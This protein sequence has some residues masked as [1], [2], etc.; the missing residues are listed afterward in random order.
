MSH[1]VSFIIQIA[2]NST[3]LPI[4]WPSRRWTRR[5][6]AT[7]VNVK[8]IFCISRRS[9]QS[10]PKIP[11]MIRNLRSPFFQA[12]L[13]SPSEVSVWN[14]KALSFAN[15]TFTFNLLDFTSRELRE[16]FQ[17]DIPTL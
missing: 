3:T 13:K 2:C 15:R 10:H 5:L 8:S 4:C 12:I 14:Q 7:K 9:S 16:H 6:Q 11:P 1:K 17:R